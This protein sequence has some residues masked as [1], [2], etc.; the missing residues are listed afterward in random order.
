MVASA[1]YTVSGHSFSFADLLFAIFAVSLAVKI[2]ED[3][4][5]PVS[6]AEYEETAE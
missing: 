4:K 5:R 6:S 1:D 3:A 2:K